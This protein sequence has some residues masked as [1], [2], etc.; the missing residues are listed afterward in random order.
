MKASN[1]FIRVRKTTSGFVFCQV[2][3]ILF[4]PIRSEI[5]S[6]PKVAVMVSRFG[7]PPSAGI[8]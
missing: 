4:G 5:S 1:D 6:R 7:A 2:I 3:T 8:T